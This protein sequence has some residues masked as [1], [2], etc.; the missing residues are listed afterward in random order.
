MIYFSDEN[1]LPI[2]RYGKQEKYFIL[3]YYNNVSVGTTINNLYP[4]YNLLQMIDDPSFEQLYL[5]YILNNIDA[6]CDMMEIMMAEYYNSNVIVLTDFN[7]HIIDVT[8]SCVMDL[9]RQRYGLN[10][11]IISDID[12]ILEVENSIINKSMSDI[13]NNVFLSDKELYVKATVDPKKL[14]ENVELAGMRND[15]YI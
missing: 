8:I 13:G 12:D 4:P 6:F 10:T 15:K 14:L 2:L 11:F 5:G 7:N 9:I 3:N 1:I